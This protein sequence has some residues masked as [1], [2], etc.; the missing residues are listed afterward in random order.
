MWLSEQLRESDKENAA[1]RA[2][3]G[4]K[5]EPWGGGMEKRGGSEKRGRERREREG[6]RGGQT[7]PAFYLLSPL[8]R[9]SYEL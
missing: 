3:I 6:G 1:N 4:G 7:S 5:A 2:R 9:M 8:L